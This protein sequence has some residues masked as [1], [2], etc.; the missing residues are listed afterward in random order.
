MTLATPIERFVNLPGDAFPRRFVDVGEAGAPL[1]MAYVDEGPASGPIVVLVHGQPTWSYMW[2]HVIAPLAGAG[3]RVIVPDLI[4]YGMSDKPV[5]A[6]AYTYALQQAR[7]SRFVTGVAG[8][9]PV[10]LV[11]HDWGGLLGLPLAAG[12]PDRYQRLVVLDTS[13]NDGTDVE[14]AMFKAGFDQWLEILRS[15]PK[16][17]WGEIVRRRT[18]RAMIDAEVAAYDAPFP[19]RTFETGPRTMSSRIPRRPED[20]GAAENAVARQAFRTWPNPVMIAFSQGSNA[21][22]PGQ[23]AMFS[24]LFPPERIHADLTIPGALHFLPEDKPAEVAQAILDFLRA[25][26]TQQ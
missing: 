12:D 20:L 7:L 14:S 1:R 23:H 9:K 5:D 24:A 15:A 26:E 21:T 2:R 8:E 18:S 11:V 6:D 4:G 10:T 19:D 13:L 17:P 25:T 16:I 3:Y 22:H